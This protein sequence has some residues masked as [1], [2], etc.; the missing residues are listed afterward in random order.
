M[1]K[2]KAR[3]VAVFPLL[4]TLPVVAESPTHLDPAAARAMEV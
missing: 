1:S 2:S 3:S 4:V